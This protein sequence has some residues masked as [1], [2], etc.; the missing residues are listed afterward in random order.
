MTFVSA[1]EREGASYA[2]RRHFVGGRLSL[3]EFTERVKLALAARDTRDLRR[4]LSGLPPAWRDPDEIARL[5]RAAKHA[6]VVAVVT[7]LW[8]LFSLVLLIAFAAGAVAHGADGS[9]A[10]GYLAVWVIVSALS[11]RACRRA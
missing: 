1:R 2:L 6:A 5:G 8:L 11:W 4:A 3:D 10:V 7:A 9:H